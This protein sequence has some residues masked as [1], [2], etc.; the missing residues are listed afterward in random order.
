MKTLALA[1]TLTGFLV[2][3]GGLSSEPTPA[4]AATPVIGATRTTTA[5]VAAKPA[6]DPIALLQK[7]KADNAAL[8]EKQETISKALDVVGE[9]ARQTRIFAKRG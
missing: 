1:M 7:I 3:A 9:D 2:F 8:I 4:P 5:P 6:V